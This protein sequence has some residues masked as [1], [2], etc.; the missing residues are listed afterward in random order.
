[1]KL[2][3]KLILLC[4][5]IV[6]IS[7]SSE[8]SYQ[9]SFDVLAKEDL[10]T[11]E[12]VKLAI[13]KRPFSRNTDLESEL[14]RRIFQL[15]MTEHEERIS[16]ILD[17]KN[18]EILEVLKGANT[19]L[20]A[21]PSLTSTGTQDE[22]KAYDAKLQKVKSDL[23]EMTLLITQN[24]EGSIKL[25]NILNKTSTLEA[26]IQRLESQLDRQISDTKSTV[27]Y[28]WAAIIG[29]PALLLA[30]LSFFSYSIQQKKLLEQ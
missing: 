27:N 3:L 25:N 1:M 30:L 8:E 20:A 12:R 2:Q 22:R 17:G 24:P 26:R 21:I 7:C 14:D 18:Y 4:S 5:T 28:L 6:M 11:D 16:G 10:P 13:S 29:I 23:D 9:E 15:Q 19:T